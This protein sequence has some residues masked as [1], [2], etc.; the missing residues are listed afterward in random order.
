MKNTSIE[1]N[2]ENKY[3][4]MNVQ[5]QIP[6]CNKQKGADFDLDKS[7]KR[8]EAFLF[9]LIGSF[10]PR[11]IASLERRMRACQE[12]LIRHLDTVEYSDECGHIVYRRKDGST[13]TFNVPSFNV[14]KDA[15][16]ALKQSDWHGFKNNPMFID[17]T[18]KALLNDTEQDHSD[19]GK[20]KYSDLI[21]FLCEA[22]FCG[23]HCDEQIPF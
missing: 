2:R 23:I 3:T 18:L 17:Q 14:M 6:F 19:C 22:H 1:I 10:A 16:K 13:G 5:I 15:V 21:S 9:D 11:M 20:L 12:N 4:E 8:A 7:R